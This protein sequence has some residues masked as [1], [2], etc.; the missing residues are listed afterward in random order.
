MSEWTL[1]DD[2][3]KNGRLEIQKMGRTVARLYYKDNEALA[4]ARLLVAAPELLAAAK[5]V[6]A[7]L[8]ARIAAAPSDSVPLFDGIADLHDAINRAD[9]P[10]AN[11]TE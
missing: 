7:H 10:P 9:P 8:T 11:E 3:E 5:R 1:Y 2:R 4:D 6:Y